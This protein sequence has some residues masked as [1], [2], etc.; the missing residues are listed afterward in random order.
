MKEFQRGSKKIKNRKQAV[1]IG[2]NMANKSCKV[3]K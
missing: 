2:L 3:K 1:A